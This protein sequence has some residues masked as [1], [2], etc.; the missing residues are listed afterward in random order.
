M[1]P[2]NRNKW[3]STYSR[4]DCQECDFLHEWTK[5][6]AGL[7]AQHYDRTGHTIDVSVEI[8]Y[9]YYSDSDHATRLA[10]RASR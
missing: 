6:A 2:R 4:A 8:T 7:A 3:G 5:N 9:T 10:E 1:S